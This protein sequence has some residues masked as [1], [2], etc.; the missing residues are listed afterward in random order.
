MKIKKKAKMN[1]KKPRE[2]KTE[3][4]EF[5]KTDMKKTQKAKHEAPPTESLHAENEKR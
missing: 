3:N 1:A 2:N 5:K 4:G